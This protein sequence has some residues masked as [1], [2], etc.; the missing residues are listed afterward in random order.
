MVTDRTHVGEHETEEPYLPVAA[1]RAPCET[2]RS[3]SSAK[4]PSPARRSAA[5]RIDARAHAR[6]VRHRHRHRRRQDDPE[7]R[8]ARGDGGGRRAVH[9]R[10]S[11]WSRGLDEP[12]GAWPADHEL[13]ASASG[14]GARGCCAAALRP[15]RLTPSG[16]R[17]RGRA[18]R[19]GRS[20]SDAAR[21]AGADAGATLIVEGVGGLLVPLA[22][23]YT[24][25]DSRRRA[26]AAAADRRAPGP[27]HDQPHAAHARGGP[28]GGARVRAVVL[29]PW[30]REASRWS[31]PTARRSRAWARSR[32]RVSAGPEPRRGRPGEWLARDLPWRRWLG[33][34]A[35]S[36]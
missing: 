10:T 17:A 16:G 15:R 11:R 30:P 28:R 19:P 27:R 20:F 18:H 21:E 32:S 13:L 9:A 24:V 29:T 6:A 7:R 5:S 36:A 4:A 3:T 33:G 31:A 14:H 12:P 8:A 2:R 1:G 25:R 23:D 26:R 34:A 22:D 35:A